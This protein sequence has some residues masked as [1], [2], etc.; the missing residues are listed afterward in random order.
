MRSLVKFTAIIISV[1]I[2][3]ALLDYS[4]FPFSDGAEHGAAVRELAQKLT[5]P[6]EPMLSEYQGASSRYVPSALVMAVFMRFLHID[7]FRTL[8]IFLII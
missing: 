3:L 4:H 1:Y 8:K 2:P 5:S 7:I 6:G